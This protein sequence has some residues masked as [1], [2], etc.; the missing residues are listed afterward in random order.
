MRQKPA[1]QNTF[2]NLKQEPQQHRP[3]SVATE[4]VDTDWDEEEDDGE[5]SEAEDNSPRVSLQSVSGLSL[6]VLRH[7][8]PWR[9]ELDS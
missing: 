8:S 2:F 3:T 7:L 9:L 6:L 1:P 5:V 4:F